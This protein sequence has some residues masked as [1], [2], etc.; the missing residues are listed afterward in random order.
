MSKTHVDLK[1]V[2][3][4]TS[5]KIKSYRGSGHFR[6][7]FLQLFSLLFWIF[8]REPLLIIEF[9]TKIS[10][11]NQI[12]IFAKYSL[13]LVFLIK[14]LIMFSERIAI[15]FS[16][17]PGHSFTFLSQLFPSMGIVFLAWKQFLLN[18]KIIRTI[19]NFF[20][21]HQATKSIYLVTI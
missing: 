13:R 5:P 7:L 18:M 12:N 20:D 19:F 16:I 3:L 14:Y 17:C 21:G 2:D 9:I 4:N 10:R 15:P 6:Y 8:V 11:D 1:K